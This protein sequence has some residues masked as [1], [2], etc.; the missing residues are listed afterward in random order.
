MLYTRSDAHNAALR[1]AKL[2]YPASSSAYALLVRF[3]AG[4]TD[5]SF[6]SLARTLK[7]PRGKAPAVRRAI[8]A[9]LIDE[10]RK[11][12]LAA[13]KSIPS[14]IRDFDFFL[15][16]KW[17]IAADRPGSGNTKNIGSTTSVEALKTGTDPFTKFPNGARLFDD[18]WT[19]YLT[20]DMAR[21]VDLKAPP[22]HN[23]KSY[24]QYKN[25]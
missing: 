2:G 16:E 11:Y 7:V 12:R 15:Q 25:G 20:S 22:Y 6:D 3:V 13:L 5:E 8:E 23:L 17:R 19:Y 18:Y 4:P 24:F 10:R 21:A 9:V 14:V 1:L